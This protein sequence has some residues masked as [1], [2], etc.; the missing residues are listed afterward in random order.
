[1]KGFQLKRWLTIHIEEDVVL[2]L[3]SS[4][5]IG[6]NIT[7]SIL[8]TPV[9]AGNGDESNQNG[10]DNTKSKKVMKRFARNGARNLEKAGPLQ[11]LKAYL[12][13]FRNPERILHIGM[14]T[15]EILDLTKKHWDIEEEDEIYFQWCLPDPTMLECTKSDGNCEKI[16]FSQYMNAKGQISMY[17]WNKLVLG[18][19]ENGYDFKVKTDHT[20]N[21][22][23]CDKGV[24]WKPQ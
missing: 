11:D 18:R 9:A 12:S 24:I 14:I 2:E 19:E 8:R 16:N 5:Y 13:T 1:M 10:S 21:S 23:I 4:H 17:L 20:F 7:T 3:T 6:Y 22:A 15:N